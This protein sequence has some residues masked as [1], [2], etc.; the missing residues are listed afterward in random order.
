METVR[1]SVVQEQR[2]REALAR[3]SITSALLS[4]VRQVGGNGSLLCK[5]RADCGQTGNVSYRDDASDKRLDRH[6]RKRVES[7]HL[8]TDRTHSGRVPN[9]L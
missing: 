7:A 3:S 8:T 2:A 5:R 6:D 9:S 4:T 1:T